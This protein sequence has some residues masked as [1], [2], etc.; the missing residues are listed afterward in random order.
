MILGLLLWLRPNC[1]SQQRWSAT[2]DIMTN[3]CQKLDTI[4]QQP[5]AENSKTPKQHVHNKGGYER[6]P[7]H[8]FSYE[9]EALLPWIW[10]QK[11][12]L[13]QKTFW[14]IRTLKPEGSFCVHS[15][16]QSNYHFSVKLGNHSVVMNEEEAGS[17]QG[18]GVTKPCVTAEHSRTGAEE[19]DSV[20]NA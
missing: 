3:V 4:Q 13:T 14:L 10:Y 5:L 19:W 1:H 11:V 20:V 16:P 2:P 8:V 12:S 18:R 17:I 7:R 15:G 6:T 9:P